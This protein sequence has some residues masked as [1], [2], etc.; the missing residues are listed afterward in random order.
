MTDFF[1]LLALTFVAGMNFIVMLSYNR[2][3]FSAMAF[4]ACAVGAIIF[5]VDILKLIQ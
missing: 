2:N 5:C 3:L 1:I 4:I